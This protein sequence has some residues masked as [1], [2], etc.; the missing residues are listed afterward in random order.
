[1]LLLLSCLLVPLDRLL[2]RSTGMFSRREDA[3]RA[4]N[5]GR[6]FLDGACC[7]QNAAVDP[8]MAS[9]LLDGTPLPPPK[10]TL[11]VALHKPRGVLTTCAATED[12]QQSVINLLSPELRQPGVSPIG[13]LD[14]DSEG[15]I[16]L[17]N[18]GTLA[19]LI[20]E[21]GACSKTYAALI[22]PTHPAA[23]QGVEGAAREATL[24]HRM[25]R[26]VTLRNGYQAR[27]ER[28]RKLDNEAAARAAGCA[29]F[30]GVLESAYH[31]DHALRSPPFLVEVTMRQGGKREVRRLLKALGY[32][33]RRLCRTSVGCIALGGLAR[34]EAVALRRSEVL[35]LY[36][37]VCAHADPRTA[38]LP[39][40][41]D[42]RGV[43][44]PAAQLAE[45]R[46][47]RKQSVG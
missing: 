19:R 8:A 37:G 1:M 24:L 16:L 13:R 40:Y 25:Q 10:P 45:A 23:G 33:T 20:L 4:I 2:Y 11:V 43:W 21:R 9:V 39:T 12:G 38:A 32:H 29:A 17:T 35:S 34:G 47:W 41:D 31:H 26:G 22:S 44:L 30:E 27:A 42:A 36:E 7:T 5:A 14:Q 6:V 28:C 3:R 46:A 15:L 18:D